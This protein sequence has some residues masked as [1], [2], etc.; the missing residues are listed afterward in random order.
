MQFVFQL[1]IID[2]R[3]V[4][5]TG[6]TVNVWPSA[7]MTKTEITEFMQKAPFIR[8]FG[9]IESGPA[10]YFCNM[11]C[12]NSTN[13]LKKGFPVNNGTVSIFNSYKRLYADG[14]YTIKAEFGFSDRLEATLRSNTPDEPVHILDIL[15]HYMAM[16]LD[17][18][19]LAGADAANGKI[20]RA[21]V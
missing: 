15:S 12:I 1:P 19:D 13:L 2:L 9:K 6:E 20:G 17:V 10:G 7:E 3:Q 14:I 4:T 8:N 18:Q 16:P 21:V 11:N 5:Q